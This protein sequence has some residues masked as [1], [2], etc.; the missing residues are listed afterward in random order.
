MES[1]HERAFVGPPFADPQLRVSR[2][3]P[4]VRSNCPVGILRHR[5]GDLADAVK[6]GILTEHARKEV[7]VH[8]H[9]GVARAVPPSLPIRLRLWIL[10]CSHGARTRAARTKVAKG[11]RKARTKNQPAPREIGMVAPTG[12]EAQREK[13]IL[14]LAMSNDFVVACEHQ[15]SNAKMSS[16]LNASTRPAMNSLLN[17]SIRPIL[18]SLLNM[19]TRQESAR[20]NSTP[21]KRLRYTVLMT[22]ECGRSV[23]GPTDFVNIPVGP[24]SDDEGQV[25]RTAKGD[26]L[27]LLGRKEIKVL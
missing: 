11:A 26:R 23:C 22:E 7:R 17:A 2:C 8:V 6:C 19:S 10:A 16:L 27:T 4:D 5:M 15:T 18:S 20:R 1:E 25:F 12:A 14:A 3:D 9:E 13:W 24:A 21:R